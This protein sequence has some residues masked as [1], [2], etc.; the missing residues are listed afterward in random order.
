MYVDRV[1]EQALT[2]TYH[3]GPNVQK[4]SNLSYFL[5][6]ALIPYS[7]NSNFSSKSKLK[8][9]VQNKAWHLFVFNLVNTAIG[10]LISGTLF[11]Y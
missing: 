7:V 4:M 8:T 6:S 2:A 5:I 10:L 1:Y 11:K 9:F 3:G